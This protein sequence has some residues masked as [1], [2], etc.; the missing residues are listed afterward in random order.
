MPAGVCSQP[1]PVLSI[2]AFPRLGDCAPA[3]STGLT[4]NRLHFAQGTIPGNGGNPT[5]FP[6]G[7][8]QLLAHEWM[9]CKV[10]LLQLVQTI[11]S[12]VPLIRALCPAQV[13][14][15]CSQEQ[16]CPGPVQNVRANPLDW[17]WE[18]PGSHTP[19]CA[20]LRQCKGQGR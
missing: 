17:M 6:Q 1:S 16:A 9:V 11:C 12:S 20:Y 10:K 8:L 5:P 3:L 13:R 4:T 18:P 14:A 2:P 15:G 7:S 19:H